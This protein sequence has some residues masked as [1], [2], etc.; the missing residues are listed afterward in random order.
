VGTSQDKHLV[1]SYRSET[2]TKQEEIVN[3]ANPRQTEVFQ[4]TRCAA[5]GGQLDLPAVHFMCKH[6]YHQR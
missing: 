2:A 4:V 1:Q 3:L 6:S 5:C